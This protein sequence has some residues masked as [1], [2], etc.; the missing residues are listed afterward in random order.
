MF[1]HAEYASCTASVGHAWLGFRTLASHQRSMV[2]SGENSCRGTLSA[3]EMQ[4]VIEDLIAKRGSLAALEEVDL[5]ESSL[6]LAIF[7]TGREK[8]RL[9]RQRMF[10]HSK[11]FG[12]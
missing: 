10:D 7:D 9:A 1:T 5:G 4:E 12:A 3:F 6:K 2:A 8:R 11:E